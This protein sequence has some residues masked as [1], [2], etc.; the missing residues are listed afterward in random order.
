[1]LR[2]RQKK[3]RAPSVEYRTNALPGFACSIASWFIRCDVNTGLSIRMKDAS[4]VA[5]TGTNKH[6]KETCSTPP[7]K[8][9]KRKRLDPSASPASIPP[10]FCDLDG[11]LVDFDRGV[12]QLC[13]RRPDEISKKQLWRTVSRE[14]RFFEQLEWTIDGKQLWEAIRHLEPSILTGVP[15]D[16]PGRAGSQKAVWCVKHLGCRVH[17]LDMAARKPEQ[18]SLV[19]TGSRKKKTKDGRIRVISCW[20]KYKFHECKV[21]GSI[22]ID[23][24][25][26][27]GSEWRQA[28]GTFVHHVNTKST[29]EQLRQ[30]GVVDPSSGVEEE[31][32]RKEGTEERNQFPPEPSH[33]TIGSSSSIGKDP[34]YFADYRPDTP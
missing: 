2:A 31:K 12:Q 19:N 15:S 34:C 26:R 13:G 3:T 28:G 24:R 4:L 18:H 30:L 5:E 10:L 20:S 6:L 14:K 9:S 7:V 17:H 22:L 21:P 29:L 33:S 32:V 16:C 25:Q 8:S 1:M 23:D 27:I 11:V